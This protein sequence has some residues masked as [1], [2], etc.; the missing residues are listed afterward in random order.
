MRGLTGYATLTDAF[1]TVKEADTFTCGHCQLVV[2][3]KPFEREFTRCGGCD[4]LI[5]KGCAA[6]Q[7]C[8]P[9]EEQL[10]RFEARD[11]L[12]REIG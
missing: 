7:V 12:R 8:D 4:R 3:V 11:R 2:H 9:I 1:G 5:C 6:R 10:Q